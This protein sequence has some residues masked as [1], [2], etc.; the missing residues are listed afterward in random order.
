MS[1]VIAR[2]FGRTGAIIGMVHLLPLPGAPGARPMDEVLER[3]IADA[4]ALVAGGVDGVMIENFGDTPF[5]KDAVPPVTIASMAVAVDAI[6][7]RIGTT[8]VGV[9]VLR[10]DALAALGIA[11]ATGA[12]FIR[13]NVLCGAMVTDQGLVEG[14]AAEVLRLR[15]ALGLDGRVAIFADVLV[16]HASPM[17]PL[18]L[19]RAVMDTLGRGGADVV[20]VSGVAT[21]AAAPLDALEEAR[22]AAGQGALAVGSGVSVDTVA[23]VLRVADVAIVGTALKVGGDVRAP[24]D[25]SSVRTLVQAARHRANGQR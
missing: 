10:N 24:V 12:A 8:P 11:A 13:V 6:R 1:D 4:R 23:E 19:R 20:I 16:K 21:G 5:W 18:S 15:S 2:L 3:A 17:A 7:R 25:P 22:S 9:N 14:R